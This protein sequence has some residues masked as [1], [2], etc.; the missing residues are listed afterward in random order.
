MVAA[1]NAHD[2]PVLAWCYAEAYSG[3]DLSLGLQHHSRSELAHAFRKGFH[4]FP[5]AHL[6]LHDLTCWDDRAVVAWSLHGTHRGAFMHIPAT[7]QPVAAVGTSF[8]RLSDSQITEA[9]HLWDVAGLLRT[10]RLLPKWPS[11]HRL[12][13]DRMLAMFFGKEHI[14]QNFRPNSTVDAPNASPIS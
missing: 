2:L 13:Q 3:I 5:D 9:L 12:D 6:A 1:F 11:G 4:A 7:G 14:K 8:Y 10:M